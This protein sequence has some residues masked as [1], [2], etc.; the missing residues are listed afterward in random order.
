LKSHA[1]FFED[2][3]LAISSQSLTHQQLGTIRTRLPCPSYALLLTHCF[4][5]S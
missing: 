4:G 1:S 5:H 2:F 3:A